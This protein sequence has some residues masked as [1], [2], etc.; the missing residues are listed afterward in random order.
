MSS[1]GESENDQSMVRK[2]LPLRG[3]LARSA[4]IPEANIKPGDFETEEKRGRVKKPVKNLAAEGAILDNMSLKYSAER[5]KKAFFN[6]RK[7][8]IEKVNEKLGYFGGGILDQPKDEDVT[9]EGG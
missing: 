8:N 5:G 4:G 9:L 6:N 3:G 1:A 2:T 7:M